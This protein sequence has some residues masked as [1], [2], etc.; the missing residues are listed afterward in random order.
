MEAKIKNSVV[1]ADNSTISNATIKSSSKAVSQSSN[2][3]N[4]IVAQNGSK[5]TNAIIDIAK[6]KSKSFWSGFS[7][8]GIISSV[9]AS[10][11]WY[12]VQ[13]IIE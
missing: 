12:F 13:R 2:M 7:I 4:S 3:E 6:E 11:I 1:A 9:V 5:I 10:T 8:G